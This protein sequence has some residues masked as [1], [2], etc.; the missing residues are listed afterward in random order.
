MHYRRWRSGYALRQLPVRAR[1]GHVCQRIHREEVYGA[2]PRPAEPTQAGS[3]SGTGL[4]NGM[5]RSQS[6]RIAIIAD[7][8][9]ADQAVSGSGT[10]ASGATETV[11]IPVFGIVPNRAVRARR[12]KSAIREQVT[13][14]HPF[15]FDR[16]KQRS[17]KEKSLVRA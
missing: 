12:S 1:K 13:G 2:I 16:R 9:A 17:Q 7:P 14:S 15:Y 5:N 3:F 10:E 6:T 8:L 11:N 4:T